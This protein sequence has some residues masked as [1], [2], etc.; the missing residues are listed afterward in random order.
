MDGCDAFISGSGAVNKSSL[1]DSSAGGLVE[2]ASLV[3]G[4]E[5]GVTG[6]ASL[7]LVTPV[8]TEISSMT[9]EPGLPRA[10][11]AAATSLPDIPR[12]SAAVAAAPVRGSWVIITKVAAAASTPIE[13]D[14]S[15]RI[16]KLPIIV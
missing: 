1:T 8:V 12:G 6:V 11:A 14:Q 15:L 3:S 4:M 13:R 9:A 16:D 2:A 7:V 5:S 10:G